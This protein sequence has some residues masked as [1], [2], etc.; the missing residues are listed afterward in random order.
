MSEPER[1][2]LRIVLK[3]LRYSVEFF[4]SLYPARRVKPFRARL[5]QMQ[6]ILGL[7][8]DVAVARSTLKQLVEGPPDSLFTARSDLSFAAG[9]VYGWHLDRASSAWRD[10]VSCWKKFAK[11]KPF[12]A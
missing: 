10:A 4:A 7:L 3:K 8:Q 1:H 5:S 12:W 9:T 11:A 2:E 6:D